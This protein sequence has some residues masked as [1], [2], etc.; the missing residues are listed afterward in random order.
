[1]VALSGQKKKARKDRP[2]SRKERGPELQLRLPFAGRLC[3]DSLKVEKRKAMRRLNEDARK[4]TEKEILGLAQSARKR[5]P[6]RRFIR[7]KERPRCWEGE[8]IVDGNRRLGTR[9]GGRRKVKESIKLEL[10]PR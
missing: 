9:K 4:K 7:K 10:R 8:N 3:T 5:D 6:V 2:E 1:V